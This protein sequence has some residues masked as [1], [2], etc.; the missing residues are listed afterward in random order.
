MTYSTAARRL[1]LRRAGGAIAAVT[2]SLAVASS[3][4]AATTIVTPDNGGTADN[5]GHAM[6]TAATAGGN[7]TLVL[8]AGSY[9]PRGLTQGGVNYGLPPV[10]NGEHLTIVLSHATQAPSGN[11]ASTI[12]GSFADPNHNADLFTVQNGGTLTLEGVSVTGTNP[13]DAGKSAVHVLGGGSVTLYG[14]LLGGGQG[15]ELTLDASSTAIINESTFASDTG[16]QAITNSGTLTLNS[17]TDVGN[18]GWGL[19]NNATATVN[20]TVFG[21]NG[22]GLNTFSCQGAITTKDDVVDDDGTCTGTGVG[23]A[24]TVPFQANNGGPTRSYQFT[25]LPAG[26]PAKCPSTDVRFFVIPKNAAN[27]PQCDTGSETASAQRAVASSPGTGQVVDVP[28]CVAQSP[29]YPTSGPATQTVVASDAGSGLGPEPGGPGDSTTGSVLTGTG[30]NTPS[31]TGNVNPADAVSNAATTDGSIAVLNPFSF[32]TWSNPPTNTTGQLQVQ[33][34]KDASHNTKG[35][36]SWSFDT[37][38]WA[39]ITVWC[40]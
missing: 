22:D 32:P 24:F 1:A 36:T 20:N 25:G 31:A 29:V 9:T 37:T 2:A 8:Q 28:T 4:S 5:L 6:S 27:Q 21:T 26:D 34:T 30:A 12:D 16:P 13:G 18:N 19:I 23:S 15:T 11:N 3:A 40:H 38:N 39:G 17:V 7:Q 33:A 10:G 35:D 14:D